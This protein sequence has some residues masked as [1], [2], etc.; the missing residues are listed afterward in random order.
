MTAPSY[1]NGICPRCSGPLAVGQESGTGLLTDRCYACGTATT[2]PRRSLPVA[3]R[4]AH[5][6]VGDGR[7]E[8]VCEDCGRRVGHSLTV[9]RFCRHDPAA[10]CLDFTGA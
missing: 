7:L 8:R 9:C 5:A 2:V 10:V 1:L 6:L 4:P 3:E